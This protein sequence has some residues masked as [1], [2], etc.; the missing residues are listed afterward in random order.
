[1]K[2]SESPFQIQ[3]QLLLLS[4]GSNFKQ[5]ASLSKVKKQFLPQENANG[6]LQLLIMLTHETSAVS[7]KK[8]V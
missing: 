1:M 2:H 8:S 3:L 6:A 7:D 5:N 4:C